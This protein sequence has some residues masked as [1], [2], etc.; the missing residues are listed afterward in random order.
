MAVE[1]RVLFYSQVIT[2][3]I[4]D[5]CVI[6]RLDADSIIPSD[7]CSKIKQMY[8]DGNPFKANEEMITCLQKSPKRG[9][10]ISLFNALDDLEYKHLKSLLE[11]DGK[12]N[13][14]DERERAIIRVFT[15][16]LE[17]TIYAM[18][19]VDELFSRK[20]IKYTDSEFIRAK[21]QTMGNTYATIVLLERM[22]CRLDPGEWYYEFL[23]VLVHKNLKHVVE[24]IEPD[25]LQCPDQFRPFNERQ[26]ECEGNVPINES[27]DTEVPGCS[28]A[29][30]VYEH[31]LTDCGEAAEEMD[32]S[33]PE[34]LDDEE[35]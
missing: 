18:D 2:R 11:A 1:A 10:W 6:T 15:P 7:E 3:C 28:T 35:K 22:Q 16:Y 23:D 21:Y 4:K 13:V 34:P 32:E 30:D 25:F 5:P 17:S 12:P 14:T 26:R 20:V 24:E 9:K 8:T 29:G 33:V 27:Y 31:M 19:I